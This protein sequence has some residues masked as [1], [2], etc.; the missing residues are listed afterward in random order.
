MLFGVYLVVTCYQ[1]FRGD[2]GF[3]K[4]LMSSV[5]PQAQSG[6]RNSVFD[7]RPNT[8]SGPRGQALIFMWM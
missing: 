2:I 7:E 3:L 1:N 4:S 6:E 5:L 8:G